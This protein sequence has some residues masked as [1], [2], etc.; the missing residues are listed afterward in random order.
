MDHY[1]LSGAIRG[2][3]AFF[4]FPKG[5]RWYVPDILPPIFCRYSE[6]GFQERELE[7][8]Q[9]GHGAKGSEK[10][11]RTGHLAL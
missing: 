10:R 11:I 8:V 4:V 1:R 2:Q 7:S 5:N 9:V 3:T 6:L